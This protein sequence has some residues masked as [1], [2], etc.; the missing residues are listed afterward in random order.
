[1]N[2]KINSSACAIRIIPMVQ[3]TIG[4]LRPIGAFSL[5]RS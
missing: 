3:S 1:M 4:D 2:Y 5:L